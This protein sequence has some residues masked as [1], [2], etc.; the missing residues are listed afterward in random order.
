MAESPT[1]ASATAI[2]Q[3]PLPFPLEGTPGN[4][5]D[6]AFVFVRLEDACP[7][8]TV[9]ASRVS[10][11]EKEAQ[12]LRSEIAALK[13]V[14]TLPRFLIRGSHLIST[15]RLCELPRTIYKTGK[16]GWSSLNTIFAAIMKQA[17]RGQK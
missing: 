13:E 12:N 16:S 14:N 10:K 17:R 8:C 4:L 5:G 11:L 1:A 15:L 3:S 7:T 6:G 9:A 2:A